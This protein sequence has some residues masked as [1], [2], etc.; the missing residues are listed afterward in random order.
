MDICLCM[1]QEEMTGCWPRGH[2]NHS[3]TLNVLFPHI[4]YLTNSMEQSLLEKLTGFQ[5]VKKFPAFLGTRRFIPH[6]RIKKKSCCPC[7]VYYRYII[8]DNTF[9]KCVC[10]TGEGLACI[11]S[12][13]ERCVFCRWDCPLV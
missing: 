12:W 9:G 6:I 10:S 8:V 5:L 11:V 4:T 7:S 1:G 2:D 13:T 3:R